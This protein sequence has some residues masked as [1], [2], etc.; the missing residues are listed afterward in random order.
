MVDYFDVDPFSGLNGLPGKS[1]VLF[2]GLK[3]SAWMIVQQY[4]ARCQLFDGRFQDQ[5][6]IEH[7]SADAAL[8]NLHLVN[9][10]VGTVEVYDQNSSC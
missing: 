7:G 3:V 4:H 2:A 8:T 10:F 1:D 9:N 5:T 6:H